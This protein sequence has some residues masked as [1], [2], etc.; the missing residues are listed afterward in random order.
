VNT[1]RVSQPLS[2]P[3]NSSGAATALQRASLP[4]ESASEVPFRNSVV[5]ESLLRNPR[6]PSDKASS[7][8]RR[9]R[10]LR[11]NLASHPNVGAAWLFALASVGA[12]IACAL[13]AAWLQ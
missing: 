3:A 4:P 9:W 11:S 5:T 10:N 2:I 12:G 7:W 1:A 6:F 8:S 13:L